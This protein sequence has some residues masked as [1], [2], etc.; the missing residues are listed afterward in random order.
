MPH[1]AYPYF[2]V[3]CDYCRRNPWRWTRRLEP[4]EAADLRQRGEASR[5]DID[6][7]LGWDTVPSNNFSTQTKGHEVI[8]EGAGQGHGI[9]LCQR[10]A[11]ALAQAGASFRDILEHYYPNTALIRTDPAVGSSASS[12]HAGTSTR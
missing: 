5:L 9:G 7:R 4:A 3:N 10:G 8:L 12:V 1:Q 2:P 6:R 11:K